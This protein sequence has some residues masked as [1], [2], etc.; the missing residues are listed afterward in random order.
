MFENKSNGEKDYFVARDGV[1]FMKMYLKKSLMET[2]G[3][4]DFTRLGQQD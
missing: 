2:P 3:K 1:Y 4:P